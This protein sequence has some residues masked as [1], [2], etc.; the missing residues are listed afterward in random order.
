MADK[1]QYRQGRYWARC[2]SQVLGE[3]K[4]KEGESH[5]TKFVA[6]GF[7][8]LGEVNSA[9][10]DGA[11]LTCAAGD[12]TVF[13][14]LTEKTVERSIEEL[15]SLGFDKDSFRYL[16]PEVA[17]YVNLAGTEVALQCRHD[18][19]QG[20]TKEKW[21]LAFQG[22]GPPNIKPLNQAGVRQLDALFGKALKAKPAKSN[23]N[24]AKPQPPTTPYSEPKTF[25]EAAAEALSD[26]SD[27]P[28]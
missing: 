20:D 4:P 24:G 18:T 23:G 11:L 21:S 26:D 3:S 10:P 12:R 6:L 16:L 8:I 9:D 15:R 14:Y 5:G 25:E 7:A 1:T 19:Y 2:T 13:L 17:G 27:C 28:F 22:G